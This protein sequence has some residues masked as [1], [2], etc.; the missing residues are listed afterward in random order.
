M[1]AHVL[2]GLRNLGDGRGGSLK[3]G[4]VMEKVATGVTRDAKFR[5]NGQL[6]PSAVEL[7]E[8]FNYSAGIGLHIGHAHRR[9]TRGHPE[10]IMM[11]YLKA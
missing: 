10:I 8:H 4:L 2:G 11:H 7:S 9:H 3:Q 6:D 5:E 1:D